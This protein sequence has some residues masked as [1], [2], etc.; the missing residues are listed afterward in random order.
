MSSAKLES[1]SYGLTCNRPGRWNCVEVGLS[2]EETKRLLSAL[3]A[4]YDVQKSAV[5]T[6]AVL[7]LLSRY[8]SVDEIGVTTELL[9]GD[10]SVTERFVSHKVSATSRIADSVE[11]VHRQISAPRPVVTAGATV[12]ETAL[13][14][15]RVIVHGES[16]EDSTRSNPDSFPESDLLVVEFRSGAGGCPLRLHYRERAHARLI[17]EQLARHLA[18]VIAVWFTDPRATVARLTLLDEAE[19]ALTLKLSAGEKRQYPLSQPLLYLFDEQAR[20]APN[21]IALIGE[22]DG[23]RKQLSYGEVAKR[24][25][26]L[27]RR[28]ASLGVSPGVTVG[29]YAERSVEFVVALVAVLRAGGT[30]VPLDRS[31][32]AEYLRSILEDAGVSLLLA[33]Q[34]V[35]E[36]TLPAGVS[37]IR[38]GDEAA[39]GGADYF[40]EAPTAN[41]CLI[42][43]T[44]GSTGRPKG[45]VH[46][47][48]QLINRLH[49]MWEAYP[50]L[51][52]DVIAQRSPVNVMPSVWELLG[53][54]LAGVPT[55]IVPDAV[56]REPGEFAAFLSHHKVSFITLTPTLLRLLL[57]A[58]GRA[59]AWPE[60]L[61]VVVIG[62]EP[63]TEE[64]YRE[65]R[66]AFPTTTLVN[67][68][69]TTEVN[70]V[71]HAPLPP[72][73]R[74]GVD[75]AGYRPIANVSSFI[76]DDF[77]R[78]V[79]FGVQ[80]ELCVAGPSLALGYLN[81]PDA[82]AERFVNTC[83]VDGGTAVRVYRTGDMGYMSPGGG[84]HITGRRDYQVKINGLRVELG[85]VER[86]LSR[87]A[88]VAECVVVAVAAAASNGQLFLRA[89]L[90]AHDGRAV[91]P[92]EMRAYLRE[93]VPH[94]MVPR[95]FE[96]R[97]SLPRRPNGKLDRLALRDAFPPPPH[98]E[99]S[100]AD[101]GDR[102]RASI[103]RAA[104]EAASRILGTSPES[105]DA[106]LEFD[107]LGFD[108][109][110]IID[111]AGRLSKELDRPIS[112]V[113]LFNHPTL[114]HL[115]DHLISSA[116][117][118]VARAVEV[119]NLTADPTPARPAT[120]PPGIAIIGMSGRFPG[121][122][123]IDQFWENLC[124]G[125]E[126]I[127]TCA[128]GRWDAEAIY[129]PNHACERRSYSKW[130]GFISGADEFEPTFFGLSPAEARVMD[131]QQRL[132]L[133]ESW[134]TLEDAGYTGHCL[135]KQT[136]GVFVG[137]REPDYPVLVA[138][139][140][141]AP[142][143]ATLLGNDMS[144]L[145]ARISYFC[146][147]R[148]P[149]MVVA[150]AC[151]SSL[152]ALSLAC[153][154]LLD[155]ECTMALAGGVCVTN[156]PDFYVA[157]SKL[158][159]FSSE[160]RCRAF[161]DSADGF[162]HG[163][164]VGFVALK[165]L[166][167]AIADRDQIYAVIRGTA[168][169]QDG[170]SNGITAP[171]GEA[172][173]E[174]QEALYRRLAIDPDT[175]SYV[176]AHGTGTRLGDPVEVQALTRSFRRF[177]TRNQY[178]A[179]GSVKTNI[180]HLTAAS[181]IAGL[182]K[183][184]LCLYHGEL[185]PSLHFSRPNAL[186]DF[187]N[188]PFYVNTAHRAWAVEPGRARRAALNAFGIG[189][190]N[191][192]CVLE[193]APAPLLPSDA[194]SRPAYLV[195][196]TAHCPAALTR[197]LSMLHGWIE[198]QDRHHSLRDLSYTLLVGRRLFEHGY[199]LIA[200]SMD[201]LR[202]DLQQLIGGQTPPSARPLVAGPAVNGRPGEHADAPK[203]D[204]RTL[205]GRAGRHVAVAPAGLSAPR[206]VMTPSTDIHLERL[207]NTADL[208]A[209]GA[210][211]DWSWLFEGESPRRIR[212][213]VYVFDR[214]RFWVETPPAG[215]EGRE[216]DAE[217]TAA[218]TDGLPSVI[219]EAVGEVLG[220]DPDTV[221]RGQALSRYGLDSIRA[222]SLKHALE[223]TLGL[224]V[225]LELL[226]DGS[227]V[228]GI[229]ERLGDALAGGTPRDVQADDGKLLLERFLSGS[230]DLSD[231][232]D[233][234]LDRLYRQLSER[235]GTGDAGR[236]FL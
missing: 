55:V 219:A 151:S 127:G 56:V 97:E 10:G 74:G 167:A 206:P 18:R 67:D 17:A 109:V 225:P 224:T 189:G 5:L 181:G 176:E 136:V 95:H 114:A 102:D 94:Y 79:P 214:Q 88:A 68:F 186:I 162:V 85:E 183:T 175:I 87:H 21:N 72:T 236:Q 164:G 15:C 3:G 9:G 50:F 80:G 53:G 81:L 82:T 122:Y 201:E 35:A 23:A 138:A 11:D 125:V 170:R 48:R 12:S 105:I 235:L 2:G 171:N 155:G 110:A 118:A 188:S 24:A 59:A 83:L 160:G 148:G 173:Y 169:N 99:M 231:I 26:A 213:P 43:F 198:A 208:I 51:E 230:L 16:G 197:T 212:L 152:V 29:I 200:R 115:T 120:A 32:P 234:R 93:H 192:H 126:S 135:S 98:P 158:N 103:A 49:W 37:V 145:A 191:V 117:P 228:E 19:V 112:P 149:S 142:D 89:Y 123:D 129:D 96:W 65:F 182:I 226:L 31:Y 137:A 47:Q 4:R 179:L 106:H 75:E 101:A 216:P 161:D 210:S 113:T 119:A 57:E 131:P 62:G 46:C 220:V 211:D 70:T 84:I 232:S 157:T 33:D 177:T 40:P 64:L 147:L 20:R 92:D 121:A 90:V 71:L 190:T 25:N 223:R 207:L 215:Q 86:A 44:S 139:A 227:S 166:G 154:S 209:G 174:L 69:G 30:Y 128:P 168:V 172:Q 143:A 140:G 27:A 180:G 233:E 6:T 77:M 54:L 36:R 61:R 66:A 107:A 165:P 204:A 156:D 78:P 203:F 217:N 104:R 221:S 130:G 184:A 159:I 187:A 8:Q 141:R 1:F 132:C 153:R 111:Y 39:E 63:L 150:T 193:E 199:V 194:S 202:A 205:L 91:R 28:L 146:N 42:M 60:D 14:P 52:G 13:L 218:A 195:P 144:L 116:R 22:R 76:L 222:I 108:S 229:A 124:A 73:N 7:L 100:A 196:V 38:F 133:M 34:A 134:R 58:R 178:C 45:V 163:E 41:P 185:V